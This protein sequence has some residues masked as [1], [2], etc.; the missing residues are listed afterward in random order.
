M[1]PVYTRG[2]LALWRSASR[3]AGEAAHRRAG[4]HGVRKSRALGSFLEW[5][6]TWLVDVALN[7]RRPVGGLT[8]PRL[9]RIGASKVGLGKIVGTV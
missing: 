4:G 9:V 3:S 2:I 1:C 6:R 5:D 8:Q 7:A